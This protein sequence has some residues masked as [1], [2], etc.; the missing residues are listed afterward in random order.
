MTCSLVFHTP[1]DSSKEEVLSILTPGGLEQS[2]VLHVYV[3]YTIGV[4]RLE[5]RVFALDKRSAMAQIQSLN[6]DGQ[7]YIDFSFPLVLKVPRKSIELSS[8]GIRIV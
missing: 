7:Y 2:D 4:P 1:F 3:A 5:C 6:K 8:T